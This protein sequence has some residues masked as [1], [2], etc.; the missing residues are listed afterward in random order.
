MKRNLLLGAL[1][2]AFASSATAQ[3]VSAIDIK[4]QH[5]KHPF[6]CYAKTC[7]HSAKD[8]ENT[9]QMYRTNA[10]NFKY[11][12]EKLEA[13]QQCYQ[14]LCARAV[15]TKMNLSTRECISGAHFR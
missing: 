6:T 7:F 10:R 9:L 4:L 13:L 8:K 1:A 3:G 15:C 2:L 5:S 11:D 14:S 12:G